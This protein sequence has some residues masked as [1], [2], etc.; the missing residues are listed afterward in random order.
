MKIYF[1]SRGVFSSSILLFI[2]FSIAYDIDLCVQCNSYFVE[3][4]TDNFT[5]YRDTKAHVLCSKVC[6]YHFMQKVEM[7]VSCSFCDEW[8]YDLYMLQ[9]V[10]QQS[11]LNYFCSISC[12]YL[13]VES[14]A[15]RSEGG[16]GDSG[17]GE[18]EHGDKTD[19][20]KFN[21]KNA[22]ESDADDDENDENEDNEDASGAP[23]FKNAATQT[24][25]LMTKCTCDSVIVRHATKR[26]ANN[27]QPTSK[28]SDQD[29]IQSKK[30]AHEMWIAT[31]STSIY[32]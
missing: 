19:G 31:L 9:L 13:S 14:S 4:A 10:D 28:P 15:E 8:D 20:T 27:S 6:R 23:K 2:I 30:V 29:V 17:N 26:L 18:L 16:N 25:K 32:F 1:K 24:D 12:Y 5:V 21:R 7:L 3:N 11:I 22:D